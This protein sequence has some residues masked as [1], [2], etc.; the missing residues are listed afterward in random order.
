MSGARAAVLGVLLAVAVAI[1]ERGLVRL[2]DA[3]GAKDEPALLLVLLL[4]AFLGVLTAVMTRTLRLPGAIAPTA[5]VI[6]WILVPPVLGAIPSAATDLFAGDAAQT[7][8][9]ALALV[10]ATVA[11]TVTLGVPAER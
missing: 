5:L 2:V 1:S 4:A 9:Q 10:V 7:A 6:G 8:Q 11:A 3:S